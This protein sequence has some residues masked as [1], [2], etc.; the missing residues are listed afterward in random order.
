MNSPHPDPP[1]VE[2]ASRRLVGRILFG[3]LVLVSALLGATA[4]LLLVYSTNLPQVEQ[5]EHYRP[6]SITELY[7]DQGRIIGSFALERRV[8]CSYDQYPQRFCARPWSRSKT[9]TFTCILGSMSGASRE[10]PTAISSPVAKCR[11][12]PPSRCSWR[13]TCFF[14]PTAPSIAKC[15]RRLLAIQI[16]RR[17]TKQQIF[18][19]YANQIFLGHGVYGFE[20]A[21][22]Y[23]FN[24][25]ALELKLEEAAVLAGLPKA[26]GF[27]FSDQ[28]P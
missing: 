7:D 12:P 19:M 10:L 15:R 5:L 21:S 4:G 8:V 25:P 1:L 17:F 26:P 27:L 18:T 22:E 14:P 9:R 13:A 2:A 6:S 24:K 11:A 16:E 28:P 23:Y 20:A 3:F